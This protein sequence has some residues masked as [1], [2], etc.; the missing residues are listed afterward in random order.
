[1]ARKPGIYYTETDN[2]LMWD[3]RRKGDSLE[4]EPILLII[5]ADFWQ[6]SFNVAYTP[7]SPS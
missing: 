1:M 7:N 6:Y 3:R 5:Y 2:A 4:K